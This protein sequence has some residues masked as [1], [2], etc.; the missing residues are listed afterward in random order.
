M[1]SVKPCSPFSPLQHLKAGLCECGT[2]SGNTF[3][4]TLTS[5]CV[6]SSMASVADAVCI[7]GL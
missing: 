3:L 2:R 1:M 5:I 7:S 6:V 4:V